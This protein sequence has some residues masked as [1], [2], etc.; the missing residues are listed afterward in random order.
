M[1]CFA[2]WVVGSDMLRRA[3]PSCHLEVGRHVGVVAST[4]SIQR[5]FHLL[6]SANSLIMSC[7]TAQQLTAARAVGKRRP[8]FAICM[9]IGAIGPSSSRSA[10]LSSSIAA[11]TMR[12]AGNA[13]RLLRT[14]ATRPA[15]TASKAVCAV[16][17]RKR[18]WGWGGGSGSG[19]ASAA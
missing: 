2:K 11:G 3:T 17:Q 15:S 16:Q 18:G 12:R 19:S 6:L 4:L 5:S 1:H 9:P 14:A 8:R 13:V 7:A 10:P